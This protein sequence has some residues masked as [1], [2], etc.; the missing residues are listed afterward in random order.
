MKNLLKDRC[1]FSLSLTSLV[2]WIITVLT[3][4]TLNNHFYIMAVVIVAVA[5]V[6]LIVTYWVWQMSRLE[7]WKKVG[8]A[9]ISAILFPVLVGWAISTEFQEL[10]RMY[11]R[12]V[13]G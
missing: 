4:T 1:D 7:L 6:Q 5:V 13:E 9:V 12:R 3:L 10:R 2:L 8:I 11:P